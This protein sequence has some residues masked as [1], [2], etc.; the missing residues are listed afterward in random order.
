MRTT[1]REGPYISALRGRRLENRNT[2]FSAFRHIDQR[3]RA[4]RDVEKTVHRHENALAAQGLNRR[5]TTDGEAASGNGGLRKPTAEDGFKKGLASAVHESSAQA[6]E[7][8]LIN[9][10]LSGHKELFMELIRPHQKTVH[11]TVFA[12]L[13]NNRTLRTSR[14][15]RS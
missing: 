1:I 11:A 13:A 9:R 6:A 3:K 7:G 2:D 4:A 12:L 10:I 8:A 14:K 5:S 15:V